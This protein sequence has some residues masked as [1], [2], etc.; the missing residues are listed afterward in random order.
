LFEE[1]EAELG[2]QPAF[3][4]SASGRK[5]TQAGRSEW[6]RHEKSDG[7]PAHAG[8]AGTLRPCEFDQMAVV[9]AGAFSWFSVDLMRFQ[10]EVQNIKFHASEFTAGLK[11][12]EAMVAESIIGH[13]RDT[14]IRFGTVRWFEQCLQDTSAKLEWTEAK[15]HGLFDAGSHMKG[16]DQGVGHA[17]GAG[18]SESVSEHWHWPFDG[19]I[20]PQ[21]IAKT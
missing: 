2:K 20:K 19:G 8:Q 3:Q 15:I 16:M 14:D 11:E 13:T 5:S 7:M 10:K 9:P 12:M 17:M 1:I 21:P 6:S 4:I 18:I